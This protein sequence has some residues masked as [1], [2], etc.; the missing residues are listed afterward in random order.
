MAP[1]AP[2]SSNRSDDRG[3]RVGGQGVTPAELVEG[4]VERVAGV[5]AVAWPQALGEQLAVVGVHQRSVPRS[6][7]RRATMLR[8]ISALPP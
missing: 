3:A 6:S 4:G 7:S 5:A 2:C 1:A 8:W